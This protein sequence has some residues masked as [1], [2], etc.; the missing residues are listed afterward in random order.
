M[1]VD[2]HHIAI[3]RSD[4]GRAIEFFEK[5]LGYKLVKN[6]ILPSTFSKKIFDINEEVE[7]LTFTGGNLVIE[8]FISNRQMNKNF[9]HI[10]LSVENV[11]EFCMQCQEFNLKP[12]SI[13]KDGREIFFVRDEDGNLF[14]I[15]KIHD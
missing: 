10:C 7:M 2:I 15:K 12:F 5:L 8:I 6:S 14:E 11:E 13:N 3:Q 4:R 1:R 9:A